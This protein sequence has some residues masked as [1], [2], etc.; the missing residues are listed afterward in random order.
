MEHRKRE[1]FKV[2]SKLSRSGRSASG[3][4][5]LREL[6]VFLACFALSYL[7]NLIGMIQTQSPARELFTRIHVVLLVTLA[8]YG[9]VIVLRVLYHLVT[10]LWNRK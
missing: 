1:N 7:L 10:R 8:M 9:V 6:I 3:L 2:F 4:P 5:W